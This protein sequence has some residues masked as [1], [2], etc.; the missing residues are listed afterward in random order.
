MSIDPIQSPVHHGSRDAP[1]LNMIGTAM[2]WRSFSLPKPIEMFSVAIREICEEFSSIACRYNTVRF[3]ETEDKP[4]LEQPV[5]YPFL[6]LSDF[7]MSIYTPKRINEDPHGL[8]LY[9]LA[10]K[11][12]G[13]I[14]QKESS[15][16]FRDID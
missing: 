12:S 6:I 4:H 11:A 9:S 8:L 10:H 2:K 15:P 5:C 1:A 16:T 14:A 13:V 3:Y 7:H